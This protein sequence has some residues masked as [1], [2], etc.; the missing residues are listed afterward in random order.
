MATTKSKQTPT[1]RRAETLA[2]FSDAV[3]EFYGEPMAFAETV[4]RLAAARADIARLEQRRGE[5]RAVRDQ[6]FKQGTSVVRM[7]SGGVYLYETEVKVP[8]RRNAPSAAVKKADPAAWE[9]AKVW[10]PFVR[11]VAP[12][13]VV[14]PLRTFAMPP[15]PTNRHGMAAIIRSYES[16]VFDLLGDLREVEREAVATL[17]RIRLS[18]DWDGSPITFAD[19]WAVGL[20][21]LQYDSDRLAQV[22]PDLWRELAT[23][24]G[25]GTS[26]RIR[27]MDLSLAISQGYVEDLDEGQ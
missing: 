11:A 8:T 19:R 23:E 21:R 2:E 20:Q 15:V 26:T 9:A 4:T 12:E 27:T 17:Q 25:G 7:G 1:D 10:K 6:R 5:I 16:P 22:A 24:S 13:S 18:T 14:L 3:D